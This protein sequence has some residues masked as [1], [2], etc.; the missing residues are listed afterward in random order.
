MRA[1]IKKSISIAVILIS[2]LAPLILTQAKS[3]VSKPDHLV[4]ALLQSSGDPEYIKPVQKWFLK[5]YSEA[6][7]RMDITLSYRILPPKRASLKTDHGIL[8]G[9]LR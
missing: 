4:I 2:L 6:L 8:D 5:I 7:S 9:E 1:N 3:E